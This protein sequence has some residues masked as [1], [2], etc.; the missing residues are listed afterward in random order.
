[1]LGN[2]IHD[3]GGQ[4]TSNKEHATYFSL[5]NDYSAVAP[6]VGWNRLEDNGARFGIHIYDE[7]ECGEFTGNFDVHDNWI[8][9]QV[10]ASINIGTQTACDT[11]V[12]GFRG[13]I[14][15]FNNIIVNSGQ[16]SPVSTVGHGVMLYGQKNYMD[17]KIYNNTFYGYGHASN[18]SN[19]VFVIWDQAGSVND[20]EGTC[21][22]NNNIF[23]DTAGYVYIPATYQRAPDN[24][25]NNLWYSSAVSPPSLPAWD[26][27]AL[28]TDPLFTSA[29]TG[30][31]TLQT[32]SDAIAAGTDLSAVVNHDFFGITR[33]APLDLGAVK[34]GSA[35]PVIPP[36][37][38]QTLFGG[39]GQA[40]YNGAGQTIFQ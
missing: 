39:S 4:T 24:F 29:A 1:M 2:Y 9:N 35:A 28:N 27:A 16:Y 5:R 10:G 22:L 14:R 8:E 11:N 15:A 3:Y 18:S 20:F 6:E 19:D 40:G 37:T 25:G 21:D 31:F 7:H 13:T 36:E 12:L 23:F 17:V 26:S 30:V 33:A 34:Y 32:G 38:H